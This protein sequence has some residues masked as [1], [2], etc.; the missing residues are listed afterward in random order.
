[1]RFARWTFRIAG[2]YGV[3]ILAPQYFLE[4]RIGVDFPPPITHPEHFY[5]FVG[6]ALAWQIA[7]LLISTDPARY[8]PM[9][10]VGVAAKC[11]FGIAAAVL[12]AQGRLAVE[13]LAAAT[14]D[15]VLAVLFAT[16]FFATGR[17]R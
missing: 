11:S 10:L 3:L 6:T 1:M 5:G 15:F 12:F 16:A 2:I 17:Y 9:M 7:Y 14:V 13:V 4:E 8:R